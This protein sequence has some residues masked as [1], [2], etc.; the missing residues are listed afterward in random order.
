ML[1]DIGDGSY[2]VTCITPKELAH[3]SCC[4]ATCFLSR[5]H[6][7]KLGANHIH[8]A[9]SDLLGNTQATL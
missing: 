4:R 3:D 1:I 5:R 6:I 7:H 8:G 9:E 2:R